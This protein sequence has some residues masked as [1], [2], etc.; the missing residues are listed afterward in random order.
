MLLQNEARTVASHGT[1]QVARATVKATSK[2]FNFFAS[3]TYSNKYLAIVRELTA[4]A[5]DAHTAA[6]CPDRPVEIWLPNEFEPTFR[7]RDTGIGMSHD[8]VMNQ[9]MQYTNG[10]TKD[11][12]N[13]QI[14]GFGIGSKSPF[15]Y[16]DQFTLR[17][18]HDGI[19]SIYSIFKDE[20][21]IPCAALLSQDFTDEPNGV[22]VSFPVEP[23]DFNRFKTA[24]GL[25]LRHFKPLPI[26]HGYGETFSGPDYI[27]QGATWGLRGSGED[28]GVV[29]GGIRYPVAYYD[30]DYSR[31]E[32]VQDYLKL[33]LDVEVPIGACS[34]T[35]SRESLLYDERTQQT[36]VDAIEAIKDE[37]VGNVPTMFDAQPTL[38]AATTA[39]RE[40]LGSDSA[41]TAWARIVLK[42]TMWRG[43]KLELYYT[44]ESLGSYWEINRNSSRKGRSRYK[45]WTCPNPKWFSGDLPFFRPYNWDA[46]IIDDL[47]VS[48][49][50]RTVQRIKMFVDDND[51]LNKILVVR[52]SQALDKLGNPDDV[53][54]TSNLPEPPKVTRAAV[55][56]GVRPRVRMFKFSGNERFDESLS[57]KRWSSPVLE[58]AYGDQPRAGIKLTMEN[59]QLSRNVWRKVEAGLISKSEIY[60]VNK[61][62][63]DKLKDF[64]EFEDEFQ[65]R[66]DEKIAQHDWKGQRYLSQNT[67]FNTFRRFV[68]RHRQVFD[69]YK[70]T[71]TPLAKALSLISEDLP[72]SNLSE[73][74]PIERGNLPDIDALMTKVADKHW[75]LITLINNISYHNEET[76]RLVK[77]IL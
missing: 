76:L 50:S 70:Q 75:K 17:S 39:L 60:L 77:D 29:M 19:L 67:A 59:F 21:G 27:S 6:G 32:P 57:P 38:A 28:F 72:P 13:E 25:G 46:I 24:V 45:P 9:F 55:A 53:I 43:Q 51:D 2:I 61:S 30:I 7:C 47:P 71:S 48:P 23:E 35:L 3:Q 34:V 8:F 4:N 65:R 73:Y 14:G 16:V 37:I 56:K 10:S 40:F 5:I 64:V 54:Y 18:V 58:I 31:R 69:D 74:I 22:E 62:D 26:V 36:I 15:S 33:P 12:S 44:A 20:E 1:M 52:D 41:H 49:K 66:L 11:S 68:L 42:H 63:S